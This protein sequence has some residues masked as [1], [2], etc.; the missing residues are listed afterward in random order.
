MGVGLGRG[1]A[2]FVVGCGAKGEGPQAWGLFLWGSGG[3]AWV[4]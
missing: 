2:G 4:H 1:G 3:E